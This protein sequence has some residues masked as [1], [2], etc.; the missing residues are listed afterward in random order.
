[1]IWRK[2]DKQDT[3]ATRII[4]EFRIWTGRTYRR[5]I[6]KGVNIYING[7]ELT[8]IDP[9]YVTTARTAHPDDPPAT[10]FTPITIKWPVP[11]QLD[12]F[13]CDVPD[14]SEIRIRMSE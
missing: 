6:W 7:Q 2:H 13:A 3:P 10:E 8:A 12:V 1:M 14:E 11:E 5:F 4:E 9:L